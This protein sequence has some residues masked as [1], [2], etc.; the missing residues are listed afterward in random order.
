V[1]EAQAERMARFCLA[2]GIAPSEYKD[3][4]LEEV[5]AFVKEIEDGWQGRDSTNSLPW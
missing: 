4:T 3:L 1:R 2:T 5:R